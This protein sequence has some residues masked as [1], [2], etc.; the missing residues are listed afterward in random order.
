MRLTPELVSR[1]VRHVDDPGPVPGRVYATDA[2][3]E[4]TTRA[5]LAD[6]PASGEVWV[7]AYGS[8]IWKPACDIVEQRV[9]RRAGLASLILP[10]LGPP[11]PRNK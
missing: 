4:A 3:Y 1:V 8:L 9:A 7:F 10:R 2:D 5:L 11:F 6:R